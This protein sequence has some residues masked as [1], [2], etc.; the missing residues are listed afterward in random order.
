MFQQYLLFEKFKK[1]LGYPYL[2]A[3]SDAPYQKATSDAPYLKANS[4]PVGKGSVTEQV[5]DIE[6]GDF[7]QSKSLE[8]IKGQKIQK[9]KQNK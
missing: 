1:N 8:F 4:K 3:T 5:I 9:I 6:G 2:K 7:A